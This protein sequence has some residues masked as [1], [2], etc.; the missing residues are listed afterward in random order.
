MKLPKSSE[1]PT[2]R[3]IV[4]KLIKVRKAASI[5][6]ESKRRFADYKYLRSVLRAY[7]YFKENNL[8]DGLV[9][10]APSLLL[11]PVRGNSH[12]LRIII[13]ATC[14]QPDLRMRSRWTR[15]LEYALVQEIEPSDLPRFLRATNGVMG[16]ADAASK[17]NPRGR[18]P[19][20]NPARSAH[21]L[22][23][24]SIE[25]PSMS[26]TRPVTIRSDR[27]FLHRDGII[28]D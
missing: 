9:E 4:D 14:I 1:L 16:C 3:K 5:A 6:A 2:A 15:A 21:N 7:R 26:R 27:P 11:A 8:L 20:V 28:Y 13:D 10:I 25:P 24:P 12:H 17:V 23:A 22:S 19:K 18:K